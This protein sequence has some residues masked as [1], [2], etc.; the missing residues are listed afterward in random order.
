VARTGVGTATCSRTVSAADVSVAELREQVQRGGGRRRGV[1][2]VQAYAE[3]STMTASSSKNF[4][5]AKVTGVSTEAA[6]RQPVP[7]SPTLAGLVKHLSSL[8]REWFRGILDQGV[9]HLPPRP[10]LAVAAGSFP[11]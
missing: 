4:V 9:S 1:W 7:S 2:M 3:S 8:E 11:M 5:V 10:S 6:R